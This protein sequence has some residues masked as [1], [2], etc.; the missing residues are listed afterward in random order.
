MTSFYQVW[1]H[2]SGNCLGEFGAE[3]EAW[4]TVDL[5]G[6]S[7]DDDHLAVIQLAEDGHIR[8]CGWSSEPD[9]D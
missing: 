7:G 3:D 8:I 5:I 9:D 6:Q 4:K 2:D 1:S